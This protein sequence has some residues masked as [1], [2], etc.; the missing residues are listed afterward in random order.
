MSHFRRISGVFLALI[1]STSASA[2]DKSPPPPLETYGKLPIIRSMS[3]SPSGNKVGYLKSQD[4]EEAFFVLNVNDLTSTGVNTTAVKAR[5]VD[6]INDQYAALTASETTRLFG[7]QGK[8]EFGASFSFDTRKNKVVQLLRRDKTLYPGQSGLG[9][10]VGFVPSKERLLMPAYIGDR[11]SE[12]IPY[13]L[14]SV[15]PKT[16]K[17][18]KFERGTSHTIDWFVN[19]EG[20]ILARED[21]DEKSNVYSIHTKRNGNWEKVY[22]VENSPLRPFALVGVKSDESAL[23]IITGVK[24]GTGEAL[25]ELRWDGSISPPILAK[26]NAEI[27]GVLS[28]SNNKIFG[29]RY[30]G[31]RPSYAFF[32]ETINESVQELLG[33][34]EEYSLSIESWSKDWSKIILKIMGGKEVGDFYLY[35]NADKSLKKLGN[36]RIIPAEW[37]AESITIEYPARDGTN[38]PAVLTWPADP[39][40]KTNIPTIILPHGGPESYDQLSFDWLAQYFASRGYLVLQPNFRGSSGFGWNFKKQGRG[41]WGGLMQDDVTDGLKALINSGFTDPDKVCIVG[42]SYGGYSALAGGAFTS[43]LYKCVIAIAPVSDLPRVLKTEKNEHSSSSSI[44]EYWTR[45]IGDRRIDKQKLENVSPVNHA[46]KFK[47]PVLLIH[48]K[49]DTVVNIDQSVVMQKALKKADKS[50]ELIKLKGGDHWLSTN[51]TRLDTLIAIDKF[52]KTHNPTD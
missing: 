1:L 27:D 19:E 29:V 25:R 2:Q 5:G 10:I 33:N 49:D 44:V 47:A 12:R 50:V 35:N 3:I 28:D 37:V 31:M 42:A 24:D 43:E 39:N 22:E 51:E 6:F 46:D 36:S 52:I 16:G 8:I 20:L 15:D 14:L 30:S 40:L 7:F 4:N 13:N 11:Y 9:R 26:E 17:A 34:Y 38:I 23:L 45:V 48:G 21:L 32:D 41:E 18:S